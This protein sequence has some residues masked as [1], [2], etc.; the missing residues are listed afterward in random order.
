M[1]A[2]PTRRILSVIAAVLAVIASVAVLTAC[3]TSPIG[4][5][6]RDP[7]IGP[8]PGYPLIGP[9]S[10]VPQPVNHP[11]LTGPTHSDQPLRVPSSPPPAPA[12]V[13]KYTSASQLDLHQPSNRI[14]PATPADAEPLRRTLGDVHCGTGA[15][16][17]VRIMQDARVKG[18][19]RRQDAVHLPY[20]QPPRHRI[21]GGPRRFPVVGSRV[22]LTVRGRR[23]PW[24]SRGGTVLFRTIP[25]RSHPR[26]VRPAPP[27]HA[28]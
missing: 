10:C 9:V 14:H 15:A 1:S 27:A 13:T 22:R 18:A 11:D 3:K 6:G 26:R 5:P 20:T 12:R 8:I 4:R 7:S 23:F 28:R 2:V 16:A 17:V 25:R 19:E 24:R 21:P